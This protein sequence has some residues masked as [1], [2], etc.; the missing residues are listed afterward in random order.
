MC[1]GLRS[2]IV[3]ETRIEKYLGLCIKYRCMSLLLSTFAYIFGIVYYKMQSLSVIGVVCG[4]II[5]CLLGNY[6]Y[7]TFRTNKAVIR[8]VLSMEIFAYGIFIFLSGGFASPYITYYLGC[9]L[10]SLDQKNNYVFSVLTVFWCIVCCL[11][12]E[13]VSHHEQIKINIMVGVIIVIVGFA[14]LRYYLGILQERE[15]ELEQLN[16]RLKQENRRREKAL[17]QMSDMYEGFGL[18]AMTDRE[19]MVGELALLITNNVSP[20]GCMFVERDID[21]T[22]SKEFISKIDDNS[23][24]EILKEVAAIKINIENAGLRTLKTMFINGKTY[25]FIYLNNI[26]NNLMFLVVGTEAFDEDDSI[27][28]EFYISLSEIIFRALD[29]QAQ[30]E[31]YI[32]ADEKNRIADE[33]HDTVIQKLFGLSCSLGELKLL[34]ASLSEEEISDRLSELQKS[35]TLTMK[36]LR[37]AIYGRNFDKFG[38]NSFRGQLETYIEEICKLHNVTIE[39]DIDKKADNLSPAQK[40]VIYRITC[41]AVNNA[42]RHGEAKNICVNIEEKNSKIYLR[43][44]DDGKG[45]EHKQYSSNGGHGIYNMNHM[46]ALLKGKLSIEKGQN[47]GVRINLILPANIE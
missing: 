18:I 45:F 12:G 16:E 30:I 2:E 15:K 20:N 28:K 6:L 39:A 35:A 33:I 7:L 22:I 19:Q 3:K 31:N 14:V 43:V 8:L 37:E 41:E 11:F 10:I 32:A 5:S 34:T 47:D 21:G 23:A 9:V 29:T 4:T 46:A 26:S 44:E 38:K 25:E 42:V 27:K 36:E 24:R 17:L 1:I 40:I 13:S